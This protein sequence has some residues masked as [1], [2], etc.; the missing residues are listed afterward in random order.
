MI[1]LRRSIIV[2][3]H[4]KLPFPEGTA[5]ADVLV[6]GEKGGKLAQRVFYGLGLAFLYKT[7]MSLFGLWKDIPKYV[8]DR[9]SS[10]PNATVMGEITPE[11]LG[12]G[13]I[14][15]PKI[16]GIMVAGGVLS[17]LVLIPLITLLGDNLVSA[18]PPANKMISEMSPIEIW[19]NYIRYIGAGAVTFGGVVTLVRSFPTIIN[20]F[21]DSFRDLKENKNNVNRCRV[22]PKKI[23]H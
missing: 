18:F 14:I 2:K 19:S 7:L 3:E 4:G 23:S 11:L 20:A 6:A 1:P 9:S 21:K 22:E 5:C 8:F 10:L 13:Y 16:A 12:V 15:G 17:W